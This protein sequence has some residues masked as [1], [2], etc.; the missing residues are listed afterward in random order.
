MEGD[1]GRAG[2]RGEAMERERGGREGME[3][4]GEREGGREGMELDLMMVQVRGIVGVL[5]IGPFS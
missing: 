5:L 1:R 2:Q 4:D 3:R